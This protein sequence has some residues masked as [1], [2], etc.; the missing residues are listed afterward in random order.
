MHQGKHRTNTYVCPKE[1]YKYGKFG[2]STLRLSDMS[3]LKKKLRK[4]LMAVL[5]YIFVKSNKITVI[6]IFV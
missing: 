5:K 3:N 6:N 4:R 2:H 1:A